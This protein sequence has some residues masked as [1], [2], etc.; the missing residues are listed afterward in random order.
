MNDERFEGMSE[1]A[2]ALLTQ[3]GGPRPRTAAERASTAAAVGRI[4]ATP[5]V[6]GGA[7]LSWK[8]ALLAM[9]LVA[10]GLGVSAVARREPTVDVAPRAAGPTATAA[11]PVRRAPEEV[12]T[13]AV[14]VRVAA[15]P[16]VSAAAPVPRVA[17]RPAR[18]SAAATV[19]AVPRAAATAPAVEPVSVTVGGGGGGGVA[20][21]VEDELRALERARSMLASDPAEAL[22]IVDGAGAA[23]LG[24]LGEEREVIAVEALHRMGRTEAMRQRAEG[25]LRRWP[26][27]LYAERVRRLLGT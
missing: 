3:A 24:G 21:P 27:S 2:R 8:G 25:F 10:G 11:E 14:V 20:R 7:W 13:T 22:R 15:A 19:D 26:R 12:V 5:V 6:A 9:A 16:V 17:A 4:A 23:G 1:S 18:V